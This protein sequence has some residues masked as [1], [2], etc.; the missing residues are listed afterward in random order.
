MTEEELLQVI[1]KAVIEGATE[2]DLSGNNLTALPPEI[3]K[4]TQLKKLILGKYRYNKDGDIV[5][6]IRNKLSYL[7]AEIGLLNQL[8]ELQVVGNR[9]T[10]LPPEIGK[11]VNL[12]SLNL[13]FNK[14]SSLPPEI[15][16]LVNL[17]SLNLDSNKLSSLPPEIGKLVNL[18]SLNLDSNKLSSLPQEIGKLVNLQSL[19]LSSNRLT[20]LPQEIGKLVNLQSLNL[21]RNQLSSLPQEIGK[22]VNLQSLYLG[23][24]QLSSLPPEIGK[25]VN[26]QSLKLWDNQLS[27]LPPEIG[28]LVNLQSLNLD[29]NQLSSLPPEI[30]QLVNLQS[31]N[32]DR[33]QL[34][35]LPPEIVQLV[36]LQSL[37]LS[38]NQ[39]SSLPPEIG[40]LV[41]LQSLYLSSNQLSSLPPEIGQL[42]NLQSLKLWDNQL[43][44]LP[45][46][47][48]QLVN[49]QSLKLWDNQLSSLPPEFGQLVNLQSLNLGSNQLSSLPPEIGQLVNLQTL[50]LEDNQ[51]SS[52]PPEFGQLVN[53]QSLELKG[54]ELITLPPEIR[55]N[56]LR[57]ILNFYKQQLEQESEDLYEA[58]FL[59]VGEG[60]AGKTSLA[61]KIQNENYTLQPDEK[62]TE[63]IEVIRW[64][65][66]QTNGKDFRVNI[67]DFGG[68]EIYHQ[69]HQFFLTKRSL[70][71]LVA[72]TRKENTD[73][74]W[75]LKVVELLS[76]N[77]PVIIIKNEKQDRQCEVNERELRGEFTNL[78]KVL[79]TNLATNRG[80][81]DIKQ[82][83]QNYITRLPHVGT[84]LPKLWL[85]VRSAL[86]N[87]SRNY[88]SFYE[89]KDFCRVNNLTDD[90]YQL[91]LSRYLHDLGV[92]LHFQDDSTLKH[93]VILKPEWGTTAVYKVLDNKNVKDNLGR[94]TKDN[95]Q[96][97]WQDSEY[98]DMR[99]ELLQLMMR[100]KLC[101]P[102]PN[103]PNNYIAPQLLDIDKPEYTWKETN[104]L[105]WRYEYKFMP[106][107]IITRFIVETHPWIEQQKLVWRSGVVLNKDQTR[108]EVIEN[109]NLK[110]I[111]IRVTG[112]R[113]K[114][115]LAVVTHELE[116]IHN[117]FERLQ[118]NTLVPC[119]CKE[120]EGSLTP[121]S[122][123]LENLYKRL[124]AG[125]YQIECEKSYEMVDVRRLI[126][127]VNL[128]SVEVERKLNPDIS[129]LQNELSQ[130]RNKSFQNKAMIN[131]HDFQILVTA[132]RKI[133]ASSEQGDEWGE[134]QLD[135]KRTKQTLKLIE[136]LVKHEEKDADLLKGLGGEL[137][138][139]LFPTRIHGRLQATIAGAHADGYEV[140][141]RL[142]F[143][144]PELAAL[145][146]EF[147]YDEATNTF[148]GNN[149]QTVL[150]RYVDIPL[151]KRDI[152]DA[153]LPLKV[154]LVISTPSNL[155]QLDV[156]EEEKLIRD[157]LKK[158][159]DSGKIE[160]DVLPEATIRNIN[161]KL[162]EKH[163][164][165]FHF[166]GHSEFE[167]NKGCIALVDTDGKYKLL[168]DEGFANFFLGNRSLGLAV[169]NSCQGATV[170]NNQAFAG[171]APN[172]VR[173]GIP[174]VVAMQYPIHDT[175]AKVFADEFYRTLA[176]GY[177]VDAA[178]QTTRNAISMEVGLD[179]P[180]FA[181]PVLYMRA[182]DGIILSGL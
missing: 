26:L 167:N 123:P 62:S 104:N 170:S 168:D 40:N 99:D 147:L 129:P 152:K 39:L 46:E 117:S 30:G 111:K 153:S 94:F 6:T 76:E 79:A 29:R 176:L 57:A 11:L 21:D 157:A 112:N 52:L 68:Q 140:R 100:F 70:Y 89:Y 34:S 162:R 98:A 33:N 161:Q 1:E 113:K 135:M 25:L 27:S 174:A 91:D 136:Y 81:P 124:K 116:K 175:T 60:G 16:K 19:N 95:L 28:K 85:R 127:D 83:I 61:N 110:E 86:E 137:Y 128:P 144:S 149:T 65:F 20:S 182:R 42:V 145:P 75:W 119:N 18:Q 97:I 178:M 155:P 133:R 172:L 132:D 45:P 71:A 58:K 120:C 105:I 107:G 156:A 24:N 15:G 166:I 114:E 22:L 4:L 13:S 23:S 115:L 7:P 159:I 77:S 37:Y 74:Y 180:D 138:Q 165:V 64:H 96:D 12:Q 109:Y 41:N 66:T 163:Y 84:P 43:S 103:S 78:E 80:L 154:L 160:L 90:K 179:K 32:L 69:T 5:D 148:L 14:L 63:G 181:T 51:L 146:W 82:A 31:L 118:Y 171:I 169:L 92:C 177:P 88:I 72:D 130:E 126:D 150:S 49:L 9:L 139:A 151:Q 48:G 2:L 158:Y 121:H 102:I 131:Y 108:A 122:Y 3:G 10:S 142:V 36:N 73:F 143:E 141:L 38:F 55:K 8:E 56:G 44:S 125:R 35:S 54:N 93:Y 59:I 53:L 173:R 47:I 50:N 134:L 164:N 106:K 67:W 101:Y 17:Q 87:D